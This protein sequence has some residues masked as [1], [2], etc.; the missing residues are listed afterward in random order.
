MLGVRCS[1]CSSSSTAPDG[2]D[3]AQVFRVTHPYHPLRDREFRLLR[4]GQSWR[5]DRVWF[6]NNAGRLISLPSAWTSLAP[7]DPFV[8]LAQERAY[9]RVPDLLRLAQLV[10]DIQGRAVKGNM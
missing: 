10:T 6:H 5:D 1:S 4:R 9:A 3:L 7:A 2:Q 8:T